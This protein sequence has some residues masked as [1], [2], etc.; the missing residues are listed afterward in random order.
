MSNFSIIVA[1]AEHNAIGINNK[2]LCY[3]SEDL[4]RFKQ[5]TSGHKIIMG[6][7][8]YFTIPKR[9]LPNRTNIV[10]SKSE[11]IIEGCVIAN[12]IE[13]V[14]KICKDEECFII[15]GS[16]VYKQFLPFANK[17]Y[18]TKIH[19]TFEA[20][21]YF[22]DINFDEWE[23]VSESDILKDEKSGILYSFID[24]KRKL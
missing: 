17:I 14:I 10:L 24:Y 19:H 16:L 4:R 11:K 6:K 1:I 5:I 18:L 8:T 21:T 20:D 13:E 23:I 7:T 12:S 2:L 9:P 15:G 3:L 22:S